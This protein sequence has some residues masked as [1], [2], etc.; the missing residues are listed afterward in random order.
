MQ[1]GDI[2]IFINDR[3]SVDSSGN[4]YSHY[5][6]RRL[7]KQHNNAQGYPQV[8]VYYNKR[9]KT[10]KVHR[11]VALAFI[12]NP[13]NKPWV[14]HIN[15]VRDDN[16]A[17]NLEWCYPHEDGLNRRERNNK[18]P[19]IKQERKYIR[20]IPTTKRM[21]VNLDKV[22]ALRTAKDSKNPYSSLYTISK[23]DRDYILSV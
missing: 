6:K 16:R 5:G 2:E 23:E 20:R 12:P 14:N 17:E 1:K 18:P 15:G 22:R 21:R 13:D 11:L 10:M 19:K 9:Q 4:V 3:Y 8:A 7:I